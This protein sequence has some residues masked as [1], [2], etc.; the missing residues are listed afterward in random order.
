MR[1]LSP[2]LS[3][4]VVIGCGPGPGV[5]PVGEPKLRPLIFS[6][7]SAD[8]QVSISLVNGRIVEEDD[9]YWLVADQ[10]LLESSG[11]Q[12]LL[13]LTLYEDLSGNGELDANESSVE[14]EVGAP[15]QLAVSSQYPR[16]RADY[17]ASEWPAGKVLFAG[18]QQITFAD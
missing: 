17:K 18:E 5:A 2:W 11:G 13:E 16:L 10:I 14:F 15:I 8:R 6:G 9:G 3:L 1:F 7:G 4:L 12:V